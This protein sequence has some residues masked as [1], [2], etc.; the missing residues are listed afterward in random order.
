VAGNFFTIT[1]HYIAITTL[2][3]FRLC[4]SQQMA[5]FIT[6][7]VKVWLHS[8]YA[9]FAITPRWPLLLALAIAANAKAT[10]LAIRRQ[11]KVK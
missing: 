5:I 7:P 8:Y 9:F 4:H 3:V 10:P 2:L 6:R 11:W 1:S